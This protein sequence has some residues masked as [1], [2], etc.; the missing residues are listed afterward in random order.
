TA[1]T[2]FRKAGS[3]SRSAPIPAHCDPF[4]QNTS[5][6]RPL[7]TASPI[8]ALGVGLEGVAPTV[9]FGAEPRAASPTSALGEEPGGVAP[10][11]VER[12][13]A[14]WAA[15]VARTTARCR[16]AAARRAAVQAPS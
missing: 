8:T 2:A 1:S 3:P 12:L 7:S 4:P 14:A 15:E 11:R 13:W 9:G 10:Y 5:A 16:W 6:T